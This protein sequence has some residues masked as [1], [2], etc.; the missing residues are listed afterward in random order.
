LAPAHASHSEIVEL[1]A[2]RHSHWTSQLYFS[3]SDGTDPNSNGKQYA[4]RWAGEGG[5]PWLAR[6]T[7]GPVAEVIPFGPRP[8]VQAC[9]GLIAIMGAGFSGS[10]PVKSGPRAHPPVLLGRVLPWVGVGV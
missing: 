4:L 1:G 9:G 3:T 8:D 5:K 6:L 7:G 2:G 10:P